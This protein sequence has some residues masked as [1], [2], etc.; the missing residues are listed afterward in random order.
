M[1]KIYV[2]SPYAG[3]VERNVANALSYCKFVMEKGYMP[4]ASHLYFTQ[5]TDDNNPVERRLG[6]DMGLELLSMCDEAWVFYESFI[7]SGM[8]GEIAR[9]K[10]LGIPVSYF[11]CKNGNILGDFQLIEKNTKIS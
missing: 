11:L 9:S 7:S 10:E 5:M 8:E 4:L 1:R 2:V 6:L 3:D